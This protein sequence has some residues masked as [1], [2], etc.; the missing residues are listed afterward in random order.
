[1]QQM[2][3][4]YRSRE[5]L[6][7]GRGDKGSVHLVE[8]KEIIQPRVLLMSSGT[9]LTDEDQINLESM[10]HN[11]LNRPSMETNILDSKYM[12]KPQSKEPSWDGPELKGL[13]H[14]KCTR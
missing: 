11:T 12:S 7:D 3:R 5:R 14:Y 2:P 1:M 8:T 10:A 9:L 13:G 4:Q 6:V